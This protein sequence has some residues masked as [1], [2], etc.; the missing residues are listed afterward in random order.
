MAGSHACL[1]QPEY[2]TDLYLATLFLRLCRSR[3]L[4]N[5]AKHVG[6]AGWAGWAC[7]VCGY[8]YI[9]VA[10]GSTPYQV[11]GPVWPP[12]KCRSVLSPASQQP[13]NPTN[14][15]VKVHTLPT[16]YA[17]TYSCSRLFRLSPVVAVPSYRHTPL[18]RRVKDPPSARFLSAPLLSLLLLLPPSLNYLPLGP[19]VPAP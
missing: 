11:V 18:V 7:P 17:R 13:T 9:I 14:Q 3:Q 10:T 1:D 2:I 19:L 12:A 6:C 15:H 4:C 5:C 8:T 16:R